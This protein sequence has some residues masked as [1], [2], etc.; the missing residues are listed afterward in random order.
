MR[1]LS[2]C[3]KSQDPKLA[4]ALIE[5]RS[6]GTPYVG[7]FLRKDVE[8]KHKDGS[9]QASEREVEVADLRGEKLYKQLHEY[10]TFAQVCPV[11]TSKFER[12][13]FFST[14]VPYRLW[15]VVSMTRF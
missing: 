11:V 8:M 14:S 3:G 15:Q 2:A 6:R 1:L 13:M 5:L 9:P 7:A 4:E 12:E 10:G